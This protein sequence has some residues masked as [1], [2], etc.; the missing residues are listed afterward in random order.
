MSIQNAKA[1]VD[2]ILGAI[3][4]TAGRTLEQ[5]VEDMKEKLQGEDRIEEVVKALKYYNK[6]LV[7]NREGMVV[8]GDGV[9]R[10]QKEDGEYREGLKRMHGGLKEKV[11]PE[12]ICPITK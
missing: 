5:Y 10:K 8:G 3:A 4:L 11:L 6:C 1:C 7:E 2:V 9:G 12:F